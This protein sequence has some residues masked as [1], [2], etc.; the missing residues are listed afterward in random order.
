MS[1][2]KFSIEA[3]EIMEEFI[4]GFPIALRESYRNKIMRGIEYQ[5]LKQGLH[6]VT[7]DVFFE[8][9]DETLPKSFEPVILRFKD[10]QRLSGMVASQRAV[11][12]S[13]PQ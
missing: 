5:L 4:S 13:S 9:L 3:L 1:E 2:L 7:K 10:P 12:G 8:S 6:E 11:D